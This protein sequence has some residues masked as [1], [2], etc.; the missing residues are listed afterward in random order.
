MGWPGLVGRG[1]V[2]SDGVASSGVFRAGGVGGTGWGPFRNARAEA[3]DFLLPRKVLSASRL[4]S[5]LRKSARASR[6]NSV[7]REFLIAP[8]PFPACAVIRGFPSSN[9]TRLVIFSLQGPMVERPKTQRE[10]FREK[11]RADLPTFWRG[12]TPYSGSPTEV[13]LSLPILPTFFSL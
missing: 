11:H 12:V 2:A 9:R 3:P 6:P 8:R 4:L 5:R 13:G 7:F 10:N 1:K